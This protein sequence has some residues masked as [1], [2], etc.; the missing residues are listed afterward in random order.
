MLAIVRRM[1][2]RV[3][4]ITF[5]FCCAL[6]G[7]AAAQL[8]FAS[9][10]SGSPATNAN[11]N[12]SPSH[13]M[14][15][16]SPDLSALQQQAD[17]GD[18][19]AQFELGRAY[20]NGNGVS[21]DFNKAFELFRKSAD[22]GN[23]KAENNLAVMYGRGSGVKQDL[24]EAV[25]WYRK[26]AEQG[27][28]LPEDNLGLMLAQGHGVSKDCKE[29]AEWYRKAA[30]QDFPDAELHLGMLYYFGDTGF[31]QNYA[32]AATWLTKS[33]GHNN[34]WAVNALGV[35]YQNGYGVEKDLAKAASFL[36]RAAD[37]GDGKAQSNLGQLYIDG[38]GVPKDHARAYQWLTL[39]SQRGELTAV[40]MLVGFEPTLTDEEKAEG[41]RLAAEW[42]ARSR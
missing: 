7:V 31:P 15:T 22:Q 10:S 4:R 26:S 34:L 18:A 27:A 32:E 23:P 12:P 13:A 41:K 36:Q 16:A 5:I 14:E 21:Q 9:V 29:A 1:N 24:A 30:E 11:G 33:A 37:Q 28:P 2:P 8:F 42:K 6:V 19:D 3:G 38:Q 39:A 25:K 17:K 20:F 35:M 40:K